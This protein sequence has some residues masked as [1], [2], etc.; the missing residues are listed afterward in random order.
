MM[1][2]TDIYA[3]FLE[4]FEPLFFK[5]QEGT[6]FVTFRHNS[7]E[8]TFKIKSDLWRSYVTKKSRDA[9]H[10]SLKDDR[11]KQLAH[12]MIADADLSGII[13]NC[14]VRTGGDKSKTW[15][16]LG[17]QPH[18]FCVID[19]NGWDISPLGQVPFWSP[20]TQISLPTPI[21]SDRSI[22]EML[23]PLLNLENEE[24]IYLV[25]AFMVKALIPDSGSHPILCIDGS[26]GS[27]KS[28]M[29]KVIKRLIDPTRPE[30]ASPPRNQED[31]LVR[32]VNGY[33]LA[34]DNLSGLS[35][36]LADAF[37]R[38]STGGGMMRR[39]LYSDSDEATYDLMRPVIFNGIDEISDRPDLLDRSIIIHLKKIDREQRKSEDIIWRDFNKQYPQLLG[40]LYDLVA[41]VIKELPVIRHHDLPRMSDYARVGLAMEKHLNLKDNFF[42]SI[43]N[44]NEGD[45]VESIISGSTLCY[46]I[47]SALDKRPVIEGSPSSV[48]VDLRMH[49][50]SG[51]R[52][53]P[54][55][56][57]GLTSALKRVEPILF[58]SG[59][60]IEWIKRDRSGRKLILK[61]GSK[62]QALE[63]PGPDIPF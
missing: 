61:R 9:G 34:F 57:R 13:Q 35:P 2:S 23:R 21:K 22:V 48:L 5:N 10:G 31:L 4:K 54:Q 6:H 43:V 29:T 52:G 18:Q 20:T 46:A 40:A 56:P 16:D 59:I 44:R 47:R 45:K 19:G 32:G 37:C 51:D 38:L 63:R 17:Q 58:S 50:V 24:D 39:K 33:L 49:H 3:F 26:Q 25:M 8:E 14:F 55:S 1:H 41:G 62:F 53:F 7:T 36:D 27:A 15:I 11:I 30:V 12:E 42:M 60:E 28:T